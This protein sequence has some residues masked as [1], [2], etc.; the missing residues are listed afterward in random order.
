MIQGSILVSIWPKETSHVYGPA[1]S[2]GTHPHPDHPVFS[3]EIP[4]TSNIIFPPVPADLTSNVIKGD[5]SSLDPQTQQV[6]L[7]VAVQD[8]LYKVPADIREASIKNCIF[9]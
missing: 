9:F 4:V 7:D 1:P 2:P 5:F 6:L 8:M 3:V